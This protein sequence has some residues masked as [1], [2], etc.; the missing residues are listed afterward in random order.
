MIDIFMNGVTFWK[1]KKTLSV[2]LQSKLTV[3]LEVYID[4]IGLFFVPGILPVQKRATFTNALVLITSNIWKVI[5]DT[6]YVTDSRNVDKLNNSSWSVKFVNNIPNDTLWSNVY[7]N[8]PKSI[9]RYT[10]LH[11]F[12]LYLALLLI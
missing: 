1:K 8:F 5:M 7:R 11:R 6:R 9:E 4:L 2:P 10:K 12:L 3:E